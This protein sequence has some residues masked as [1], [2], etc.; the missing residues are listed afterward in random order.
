MQEWA[1]M[2]AAC[3][4]REQQRCIGR[5][6]MSICADVRVLQSLRLLRVCD[7]WNGVRISVVATNC[8]GVCIAVADE[9][10][11]E[12]F[13]FGHWMSQLLAC[14]LRDQFKACR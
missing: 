9:E 10:S 11:L 7:V 3:A 8:R 13:S 2:S 5:K 4:R 1:R 6:N 14:F 12:A